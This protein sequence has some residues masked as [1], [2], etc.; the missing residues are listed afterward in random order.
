MHF[1]MPL[2]KI[3]PKNNLN[4]LQYNDLNIA[5]QFNVFETVQLTQITWL[6]SLYLFMDREIESI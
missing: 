1:E 5:I 2:P 6:Y 3:Q 4:F